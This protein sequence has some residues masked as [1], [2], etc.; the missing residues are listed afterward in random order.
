M[1]SQDKIYNRYFQ[2]AFFSSF[3]IQG[4]TIQPS[5]PGTYYIDSWRPACPLFPECEGHRARLFTV[6]QLLLRS[7][8]EGTDAL[9]GRAKG[10]GL[11]PLCGSAS[12]LYPRAWAA[13]EGRKSLGIKR[14]GD[15][16]KM[17]GKESR[18]GN[19]ASDQELIWHGPGPELS[20]QNHRTAS[21]Q[22]ETQQYTWV[23]GSARPHSRDYISIKHKNTSL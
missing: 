15:K 22:T 12:A 2:L 20:S 4:L 6:F 10:T 13:Q 9:E 8:A 1:G 18:A 3:Q 17:A 7:R 11:D 14:K 23:L 5:W 16:A 21:H 19:V